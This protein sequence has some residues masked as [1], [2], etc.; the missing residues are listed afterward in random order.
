MDELRNAFIEGLKKKYGVNENLANFLFDRWH[1]KKRVTK[2][3]L[4]SF[5]DSYDIKRFFILNH[6]VNRAKNY[7]ISQLESL[8][9][10]LSII[11]DDDKR[12][13]KDNKY[14]FVWREKYNGMADAYTG[15]FEI[16]EP[17]PDDM[18]LTTYP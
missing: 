4:N 17:E 9:I 13:F 8:G 5:I 14:G 16:V 18:H 3:E 1:I 12:L 2:Y 6:D 11:A 15:L 10:E 7:S